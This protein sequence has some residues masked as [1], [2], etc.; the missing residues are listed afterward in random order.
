MTDLR[1]CFL[2]REDTVSLS[3]LNSRVPA[4][5]GIGGTSGRG[6]APAL[7]CWQNHL[8]TIKTLIIA[9]ISNVSTLWAGPW[10]AAHPRPA[11]CTVG[12]WGEGGGHVPKVHGVKC[13]GRG[14]RLCSTDGARRD[15]RQT[16]TW[17]VHYMMISSLGIPSID[18]HHS[19]HTVYI[20]CTDTCHFGHLNWYLHLLTYLLLFLPLAPW[21]FRER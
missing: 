4:A 6:P 12:R 16:E 7:Q 3:K 13:R 10:P 11:G 1:T 5:F 20:S 9:S 14:Q 8:I 15:D 19:T 18:F 17:S 21:R 2:V